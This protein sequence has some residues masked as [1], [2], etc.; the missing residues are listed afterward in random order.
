MGCY[1]APQGE[2]TNQDE[3]LWLKWVQGDLPAGSVVGSNEGL[4]IGKN[5]SC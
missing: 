1:V 2:A 5:E 3:M 4:E